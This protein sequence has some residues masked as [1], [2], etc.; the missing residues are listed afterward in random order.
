MASTMTLTGDWLQSAGSRTQTHGTGNL[1]VYATNGVAVTAAQL[2]LG[3]IDSLIIN[4]A[5]GYTF[6]Y[7]A[8]TGKIKAYTGGGGASVDGTAAKLS[9]VGG[10]S[11][12]PA[13]QITPD[14]N[15]GIIGKT[16]ATTV[17]AATE[18]TGLTVVGGASGEVD[19][20]TN[21]AGVTFSWVAI[22]Q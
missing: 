3:A 19:N 5:G 9:I 7:V 11:A 20:S 10:Q 12:G 8:S 6:E 21:L 14:S 2:G 15:S 4:P 17:T 13:L 18:I 1:G 16:T 22:G